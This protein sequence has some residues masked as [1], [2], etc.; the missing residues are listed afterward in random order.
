[1]FTG[2]D[3]CPW[4]R[5]SVRSEVLIFNV[6]GSE[7]YN[8]VSELYRVPS[9]FL[10]TRMHALYPCGHTCTSAL[11]QI[12]DTISQVRL[13]IGGLNH[14]SALGP[15]MWSYVIPKL[16]TA[17]LDR[18]TRIKIFC[19]RF[20]FWTKDLFRFVNISGVGRE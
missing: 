12:S 19:Y 5:D 4:F 2:A 18:K 13:T 15:N 16:G 20:Y 17:V 14:S 10:L 8:P 1:M 11:Q 7:K 9:H 6:F 3:P